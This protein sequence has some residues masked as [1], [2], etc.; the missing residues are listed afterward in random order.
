MKTTEDKYAKAVLRVSCNTQN[1]G[2][3]LRFVPMHID[4]NTAGPVLERHLQD[5]YHA[6]MHMGNTI[7][8]T[9][10]VRCFLDISEEGQQLTG[11]PVPALG[12]IRCA[13]RTV[14]N[15]TQF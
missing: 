9:D 4:A 3:A 1:I 14:A 8:G 6:E 5:L 11:R 7:P 13:K 15:I 12:E 10:N 2:S